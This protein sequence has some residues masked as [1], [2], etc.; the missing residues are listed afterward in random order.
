MAQSP[1]SHRHPHIEPVVTRMELNLNEDDDMTQINPR[2]R[3]IEHNDMEQTQPG[4]LSDNDKME[5]SEPERPPYDEALE[6]SDT[7]RNGI[8]VIHNNRSRYS[9]PL[10]KPPDNQ[11][12]V[13]AAHSIPRSK[14]TSVSEFGP[15]MQA[16]RG[17]GSA[18]AADYSDS[19]R[20]QLMEQEQR[21]LQLETEYQKRMTAALH[22]QNEMFQEQLRIMRE[23][24]IAVMN[25]FQGKHLKE[26]EIMKAATLPPSII[27]RRNA[28][29]TLTTPTISTRQLDPF[30]V[31]QQDPNPSSATQ[32][33]SSG[34]TSMTFIP[35]PSPDFLTIVGSDPFSTNSGPVPSSTNSL[36]VANPSMVAYSAT[37]INPTVPVRQILKA[38]KTRG[39]A[40]RIVPDAISVDVNAPEPSSSH[41]SFEQAENIILASGLDLKTLLNHSINYLKNEWPTAAHNLGFGNLNSGPSSSKGDKTF[42]RSKT[43]PKLELE[44][45]KKQESSCERRSF[46]AQYPPPWNIAV[47]DI[48][49]DQLL[50]LLKDLDQPA[51][52][53]AYTSDLIIS[54]M[55]RLKAAWKKFRPWFLADGTVETAN[56]LRQHIEETGKTRAAEA[57]HR[58]RRARKFERRVKTVQMTIMMDEDAQINDGIAWKW[59]LKVLQHLGV[60]GMSSEDTDNSN[61][62]ETINGVVLQY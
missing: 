10:S 61:V 37:I 38:S 34:P 14:R 33:G 59:L 1:N 45:E 4:D 27:H 58:S 3:S 21:R 52:S 54:K 15:Q 24:N 17:P 57:R 6:Q 13:S 8:L 30:S 7:E 25:E 40:R 18:A 11:V 56:A 29:S 42:G 47:I 49:H 51:R 19:L 53:N 31:T 60:D 41:P 35:G 9:T 55:S 36:P 48:I 20:M 46:L 28:E 44:K 22:Q 32:L 39:K 26:M 62:I 2:C 12:Q 16:N 5:Q 50:Q 23:G 43:A